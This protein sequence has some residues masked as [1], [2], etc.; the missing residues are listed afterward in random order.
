MNADPNAA[1]K[2]SET[3]I[4]NVFSAESTKNLRPS[5]FISVQK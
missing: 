4:V 5:A 1:R 3:L 2:A